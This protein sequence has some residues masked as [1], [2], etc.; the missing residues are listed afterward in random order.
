ML[1]QLKQ[2]GRLHNLPVIMVSALNELDSVVRCIEIGAVDYLAKPF[3]PVLLS[4]RIGASLEKKRLRDE[5]RTHLARIEQ[6]LDAAREL[7][8]SFAVAN[9]RLPCPGTTSISRRA[10][11]T[12][13]ASE[14]VTPLAVTTRSD[15]AIRVGISVV[16]P[17]GRRCG[18]VRAC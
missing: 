18:R 8:L 10:R 17:N 9:G 5:V 15:A 2:E 1:E 16:N 7:L 6:E 11:P 4:A 13:R 14:Q 12:A 3:N